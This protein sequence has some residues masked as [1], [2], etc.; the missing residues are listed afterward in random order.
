[1]VSPELTSSGPLGKILKGLPQ[2]FPRRSGL[3][4]RAIGHGSS[5]FFYTRPGRR[6]I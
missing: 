6:I 2:V 4:A 5:E 3:R 1:M